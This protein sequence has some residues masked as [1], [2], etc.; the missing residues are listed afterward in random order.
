MMAVSPWSEKEH[1]VREVFPVQEVVSAGNHYLT[2]Q[3]NGERRNHTTDRRYEGG[4]MSEPL[5]RSYV[6][7]VADPGVRVSLK[8]VRLRWCWPG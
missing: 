1:G 5:S 4:N 3:G 6:A 7:D 8:A 2:T